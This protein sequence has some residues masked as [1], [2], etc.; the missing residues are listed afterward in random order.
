M[1]DIKLIR[2]NPEKVK[3]A[4]E[5]KNIHIDMEAIL[6]Q[7]KKV[8]ELMAEIQQ[9]RGERNELTHG[10]QG[11]PTEEQIFNGK[12]LREK[13]QKQ[14]THLSVFENDLNVRLRDLPAIPKDDV[15]VGKDDTEN[16]VIRTVGEIPQFSFK[17]RDHLE[18]GELLNGIDME[19]AAKVSGARF[20]YLKNDLVLL[21]FALVQFALNT[22]IQEGF[23]PVV[24]PELI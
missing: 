22:L 9:L 2:E 8:R 3:S 19:R 16:D 5:S 24:T 15:K 14:E 20:G 21:E 18:L 10:I 13:I 4:A 17:V 12:Q 23:T 7:D 11:K 1:I 6:N